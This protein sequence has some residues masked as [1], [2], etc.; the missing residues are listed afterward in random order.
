M[1]PDHMPYL[2]ALCSWASGFLAGWVW[3]YAGERA[4]DPKKETRP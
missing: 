1:S 2:V 4:R 3:R